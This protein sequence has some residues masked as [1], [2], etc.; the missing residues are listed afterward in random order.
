MK[1]KCYG[2]YDTKMSI[3]RRGPAEVEI[4]EYFDDTLADVSEP[5]ISC[6]H[7]KGGLCDT[8]YEGNGGRAC[9]HLARI[10]Y[11][12]KSKLERFLVKIEKFAFR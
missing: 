6:P 11:Q 3:L 5:N 1:I 2:P 10:E 12:K 7:L 9:L 4:T 8:F